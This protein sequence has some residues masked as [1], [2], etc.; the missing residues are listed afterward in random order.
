MLVSDL[1]YS[2]DVIGLSETKIKSKFDLT[3]N[4]GIEGDDFVSKQTL[5]N[6]GGVGLNIKE[7][8]QFHIREDLCSSTKAF[9]S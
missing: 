8:I 7:V 4:N 3:S 1:Q 6:A 2:F 5:T 9:E